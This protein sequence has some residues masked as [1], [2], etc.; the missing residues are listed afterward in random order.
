MNQAKR[1]CKNRFGTVFCEMVEN[2]I[3]PRDDS[4][5]HVHNHFISQ[6]KNKNIPTKHHE[7][8]INIMTPIFFDVSTKPNA[9]DVKPM[10][11]EYAVLAKASS[12]Y[13]NSA[14]PEIVESYLAQNGIAN[15][16]TIDYD[17]STPDMLVAIKNDT[18]KAVVAF[19]GSENMQDWVQNAE[20]IS[21]VKN[22]EDSSYI[23]KI[24]IDLENVQKNYSIEHLA[25]FSKGGHAALTL[26]DM[27]DID[28]ITFSPVISVA[29][30]KT[31][32]KAKHTI[33]NT[34]EDV[35][36]ILA[37][38]LKVLKQ[39]RVEVN[40]LEPLISYDTTSPYWSHDLDNYIKTD[41]ERRPSHE[42]KLIH[43]SISNT[44]QQAELKYVKDAKEII[45]QNGSFTNFIASIDHADVI[46]DTISKRVVRNGIQHLAWKE[47]GGQFTLVEQ[48]HLTAMAESELLATSKRQREIFANSSNHEQNMMMKALQEHG[49]QLENERNARQKQIRPMKD[50]I[51][52]GLRESQGY[53]SLEGTATEDLKANLSDKLVKGKQIANRAG[54]SARGGLTG[55]LTG[56]VSVLA[57]NAADKALPDAV[58]NNLPT[59][60]LEAG[61]MGGTAALIT[62]S[63]VAPM[64]LGAVAGLEAS[65]AVGNMVDN[66][67]ENADP[68]VRKHAKI[69]AEG[70]VGGGV[71]GFTTR[72]LGGIFNIVKGTALEAIGLPTSEFGVGIAADI[73][74]G[75]AIAEGINEIYQAFSGGE[76][77]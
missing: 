60:E 65:K 46:D 42:S 39:S 45:R 64:A 18:G 21:K 72:V 7:D 24:K 37:N 25:G 74:G 67:T 17:V 2:Q 57:V 19:R 61:I 69:V 55:G 4:F 70:A 20:Y 63:A 3:I 5:H 6:V 53:T 13:Y 48:F 23:K 9:T 68:E 56:I 31:K 71:A 15:K 27:Y 54:V 29:N 43:D 36:S 51:L 26:G 16:Y 40:T 33:Y 59:P 32:A 11:R 8:V 38:P 50:I 52:K 34:T 44:R 49:E 1:Y 47:A 77:K 10:H 73:A 62:G 75:V 28:S 35:A 22:A 66:L 41:V 30:L 12:E 58:K 76:D 14:N